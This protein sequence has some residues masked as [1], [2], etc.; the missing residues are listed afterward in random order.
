M[1]NT[2][3]SERL[4][5]TCLHQHGGDQAVLIDEIAEHKSSVVA[6]LLGRQTPYSSSLFL[7]TS[8]RLEGC[9]VNWRWGE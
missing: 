8:R 5:Y 2:Q 1:N 4:S 7:G 9:V 6:L 3:Q